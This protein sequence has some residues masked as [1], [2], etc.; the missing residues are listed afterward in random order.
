M[1]NSVGWNPIVLDTDFASFRALMNTLLGTTTWARGV[2]VKKLILAV[3]PGGAATAGTVAIQDVPSSNPLYPPIAVGT[4]ALDV[5][6]AQDGPFTLDELVWI[7]DFK[8]TGLTATGTRLWLWVQ[9]R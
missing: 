1:A 6:V 4:Q 2:R 3:G 7:Q 9:F 8:V 5:V